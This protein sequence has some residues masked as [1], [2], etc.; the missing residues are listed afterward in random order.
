MC[1]A[2]LIAGLI[3]TA[4]STAVTVTAEQ[5]QAK[6]QANYQKQVSQQ[7]QA[8]AKQNFDLQVQTEQQRQQQENEAAAQ[9]AMEVQSRDAQALG[10]AK[11]AGA[12]ANVSGNSIDALLSEFENHESIDQ[13]TIRQNREMGLQQSGLNVQALRAQGNSRIAGLPNQ[14]INT[15]E[16]G[17]VVGGIGQGVSQYTQYAR[18]QPQS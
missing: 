18:T 6:S 12:E 14:R 4:A 17:T 2:T 7:G 11:V 16:L 13:E 3:I 8:A 1:E 15:N 9:T 5:Q 10:R